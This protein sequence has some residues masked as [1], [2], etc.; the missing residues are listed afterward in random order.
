MTLNSLYPPS[1]GVDKIQVERDQGK[2]SQEWVPV[3]SDIVLMA[4]EG[5]PN[6]KWKAQFVR[7]PYHYGLLPEQSFPGDKIGPDCLSGTGNGEVSKAAMV[8][9]LTEV[10][11]HSS[12]CGIWHSVLVTYLFF[13]I[14]LIS[15][16]VTSQ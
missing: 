15:T 7:Y 10:H 1:E 12:S 2:W 3:S 16:I 13:T 4:D 6:Q 8:S 9:F 14:Y 5:G 11:H